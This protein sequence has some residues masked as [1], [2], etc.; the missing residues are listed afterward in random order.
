MTSPILCCAWSKDGQ[1]LALGHADGHLSIR[2][3]TGEET[4]KLHVSGS[5]DCPLYTLAWHV[6]DEESDV[7]ACAVWHPQ[8]TIH[9]V[10]L[11]GRLT[12]KPKALQDSGKGDLLNLTFFPEGDFYIAGGQSAQLHL[13]N[14][15]DVHVHA[16]IRG[17]PDTINAK[18]WIWSAAIRPIN[19]TMVVTG[20][21]DGNIALHQVVFGT[22]HGLHKT[23]Y[24]YR[25]TNLTDVVIQDV[26]SHD[27][28]R[29][30]VKEVVRRISVYEKR[31]AVQTPTKILIY[32]LATFHG[33]ISRYQLKEKISRQ[34][35]DCSL[36]ILTGMHTVLCVEHRLQLYNV[37]GEKER[38]W[39]MASSIRYVKVIGGMAGKEGLIVGLK[40]GA[41]LQVFV[42]NPFHID[43][44]PANHRFAV[45]CLDLS[46][47]RTKLAVVD[48]QNIC[49]VYDLTTKQLL[50]Q[51]PNAS[52]VA[53]NALHDDILCYSGGGLLSTKTG[54]LPA[55]HQ[56]L[57]GF[58]VGFRGASV[59]CLN[60]YK[61]TTLEIPQT[62]ALEQYIDQRHFEAAFGVASLGVP[63]TDWRKL[64]KAA[65]EGLH[66]TIARKAYQRVGSLRMVAAIDTLRTRAQ[67]NV[68]QE[69]KDMLLLADIK[70]ILGH[71]A[72]VIEEIFSFLFFF[73]FIYNYNDT[74][75]KIYIKFKK[76]ARLYRK[77]GHPQKAIDMYVDLQVW[78]IALKIA[79]ESGQDTSLILRQRATLSLHTQDT[80]TAAETYMALG[81]YMQAVLLYIKQGAWSTLAEKIGHIPKHEKRA[82]QKASAAFQKFGHIDAYISTL[83]QMEDWTPLMSFYLEHALF[84]QALALSLRQPHLAPIFYLPYAQHLAAQEQYLEANT[85]FRRAGRIDETKRILTILIEN[86]IDEERFSDASYLYWTLSKEIK[87][88]NFK[89][90]GPSSIQASS[91][92]AK[93]E[94]AIYEWMADMYYAYETVHRFVEDV[95]TEFS[96]ENAFYAALFLIQNAFD[97][98]EEVSHNQQ[99]RR[100]LPDG[101]RQ[102]HILTA[103]RRQGKQMGAFGVARFATMSLRRYAL[104]VQEQDANAVD[105]L[106]LRAL[107]EQDDPSLQP[108][109][110]CCARSNDM[111]HRDG[112]HCAT[113]LEP[114]LISFDSFRHLPL[115]QFKLPDDMTDEEAITILHQEADTTTTTSTTIPSSSHDLHRDGDDLFLEILAT[116]ERNNQLTFEPVQVTRHLLAMFDASSVF[117]QPA[118]L[119]SKNEKANKYYKLMEPTMH[120]T[121]CPHCHHFFH[122]DEFEFLVLQ[123]GNTCPFCRTPLNVQ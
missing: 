17:Y 123:R 38:E 74:Y 96:P 46:A 12:A 89:T 36:L 20:T 51:E 68:P 25:D 113:C 72:D 94:I 73:C 59:Y 77:A 93:K 57:T 61:M 39:T 83:E 101:I 99:Q 4:I 31:L 97:S 121:M 106:L 18:Q 58:V 41:V 70:A 9:H 115:V 84:D 29:V 52:S 55:H 87:E 1:H 30:S 45:R 50:Y 108:Y 81:D 44:I 48:D 34:D 53:W 120:I 26:A 100:P 15:E 47:L 104:T 111:L 54:L 117:I 2:S 22:V 3:L 10:H 5:V 24:A 16:I 64:A 69:E 13:Y 80:A 33:G 66:L 6:A 23:R 79:Q 14:T 76:A 49:S 119:I 28:L 85:Y 102:S 11:S 19:E 8:R 86:A 60:V 95:F 107:P 65:F 98:I 43:L 37:N 116:A 40:D 112:L 88:A 118:S 42:N 67:P 7:I 114:Y 21:Q 35:L 90:D 122:A 75:L 82:L 56:S 91:I 32:A 109:C 110:A 27:I 71:Y 62:P 105:G 103:L 92:Q 63:D 78:D